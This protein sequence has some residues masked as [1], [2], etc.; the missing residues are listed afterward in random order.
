[1]DSTRSSRPRRP[2]G[3]GKPR[4]AN[5]EVDGEGPGNSRRDGQPVAQFLA[6]ARDWQSMSEEEAV[7]ALTMVGETKF[8]E[9]DAREAREAKEWIDSGIEEVVKNPASDF[10][11]H[12]PRRKLFLIAVQNLL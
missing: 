5:D 1:M 10:S 4:R 12:F 11:Q 2:R 9:F 8:S 6:K 7:P 3:R